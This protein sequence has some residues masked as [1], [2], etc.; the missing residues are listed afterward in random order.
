M[1]VGL[2]CLFL[3]EQACLQ[4]V[5]S[6]LLRIRCCRHAAVLP[7]ASFL[8]RQSGSLPARVS[9]G[10]SCGPVVYIKKIEW[11]MCLNL[12]L[13]SSFGARPPSF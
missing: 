2:E 5:F 10:K 8:A 1:L 6:I 4:A 13:N 12:Y 3:L 7:Q 9:F 11:D